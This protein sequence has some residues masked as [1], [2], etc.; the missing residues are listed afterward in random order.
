MHSKEFQNMS[1]TVR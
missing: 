1:T